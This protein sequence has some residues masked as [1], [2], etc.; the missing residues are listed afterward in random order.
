MLGNRHQSF[1]TDYVRLPAEIS[2]R[3]VGRRYV[4]YLDIGFLNR[5]SGGEIAG[6]YYGFRP[7]SWVA[8]GQQRDSYQHQR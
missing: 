3:D 4:D 6:R 1:V 2:G 5:D 8:G 7:W